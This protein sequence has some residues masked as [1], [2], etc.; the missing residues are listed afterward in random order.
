MRSKPNVVIV[1]LDTARAKEALS[2][3]PVIMPTLQRLA[4]KGTVMENAYAS[5][6]WTLPS[7]A[8]LFTG[9]NPSKHGAHGDHLYLDDRFP[10]LAETFVSAGYETLAISNNT[11][12]TNEFGFDRG[13]NTFLKGWQYL[14]SD[15]D[16]GIIA[17][18]LSWRGKIRTAASRVLNGNPF[19][20]LINLCYNEIITPQTDNGA[21]RTT[22]RFEAWLTNRD[23]DSPFFAFLNYIEPHLQYQPPREHAERFLPDGFSYERAKSIRQDPCAYNT[24]QYEMSDADL[25]ALHGLYC[26]ELS[27]VD[28]S[29]DQ[30]ISA[31]INVNEWDDTILLVLGDHGENIGDHGFLGHQYNIYDTLLH[32]PLVLYGGPFSSG[33]REVDNFVQTTD[34]PVTLLDAADIDDAPLRGESQGHSFHPN[35]KNHRTGIVAEYISPQ[36]SITT[37]ENRYGKLP[38]NVYEFDR[39][40]RA[41]RNH[42]YKYIQGSDG[43]EELYRISI[44]P[45][46]QINLINSKPEM[47]AKF[48][49][50]LTA[51]VS[52]FDHADA[53]S[54]VSISDATKDRLSDLGYM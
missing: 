40:L 20:N 28:Q 45:S 3:Q 9:V 51:W 49:K 39:T 26:G 21:A 6:P 46:E 35:V 7:H 47:A 5:A 15:T 48:R 44:D 22:D 53:T 14:Q 33:V 27:Y 12:I 37:L 38:A 36:P 19:V 41:I 2:T 17:H 23:T 1:V 16:L 43:H 4:T 30:L 50:E 10:T 18:E 29:L 24:R 13:F 11:W 31:L 8:S 52:S 54:E 34:I 42:D 32:V 25:A